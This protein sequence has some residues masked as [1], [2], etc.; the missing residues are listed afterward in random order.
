MWSLSLCRLHSSLT[1]SG[2][3]PIYADRH[4]QDEHQLK[5]AINWNPL[6]ASGRKGAESATP[7]AKS[8]SE[9]SC[10]DLYLP[11]E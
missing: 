6:D 1:T 2:Q 5:S 10:L 8:E 7:S 4:R 9:P 3:N 11:L